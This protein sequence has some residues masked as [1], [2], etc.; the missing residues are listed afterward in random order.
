MRVRRTHARPGFTLVEVLIA[1]GVFTVLLGLILAK[2][3]RGSDDSL[4]VRQAALLVADIRLAQEQTSAGATLRTCTLDT[5][6]LCTDDAACGLGTCAPET[7]PA[8]GYGVLFTCPSPA[9]PASQIATSAL[10]ATQYATVGDLVACGAGETCF[11]PVYGDG[12]DWETGA[13]DGV[14]S[15]YEVASRYKGDPRFSI[16]DLDAKVAVQDVRLTEAETGA[17]TR[18][19]LGSP[20]RGK[21]EPVHADQVPGDYPFQ[22]LMRFLPPGGRRVVLNDNISDTTAVDGVLGTTG[23][24]WA[25]AEVMLGLVDRPTDCRVVRMTKEGVISQYVDENCSFVD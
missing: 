8:G 9:Y 10:G 15:V 6:T 17:T 25:Q 1:M 14:V 13:A 12:S 3:D 11:P 24:A 4:L 5:G 21:L 22:V 23:K 2:Y 20:W 18:C 19:A 16:H 7:T